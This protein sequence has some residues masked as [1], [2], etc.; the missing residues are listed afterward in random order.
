M[1]EIGD[2]LREWFAALEREKQIL[3]A[4]GKT[5]AWR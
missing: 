3:A 4:L 2:F 1:G 5:T